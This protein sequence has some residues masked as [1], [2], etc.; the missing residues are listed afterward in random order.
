MFSQLSSKHSDP[1][2]IV[3]SGCTKPGKSYRRK[4]EDREKKTQGEKKRGTTSLVEFCKRE[5]LNYVAKTQITKRLTIIETRTI[6]YSGDA[7][8]N[9]FIL[10]PIKSRN[11]RKKNVNVT[12]RVRNPTSDPKSIPII[13]PEAMQ[14][15]IRM[16]S[17]NFVFLSEFVSSFISS[18]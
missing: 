2:M 13:K 11:S 12:A 16:Y 7:S 14:I 8:I 10:F 9:I 5:S 17:T 4:T 18:P 15:A 3:Q 6:A 1:P